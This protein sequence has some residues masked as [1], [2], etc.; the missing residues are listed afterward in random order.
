MGTSL[1][2]EN[3]EKRILLI[4]GH[5]VMLDRDLASIYGVSTGRLNEQV[6]RNRRRFP[7]DFMFQLTMEEAV[8][9]ISQNAISNSWAKKG[10][11][12]PPYAFTEHGAVMLASV[13]NSDIAVS[14]SIQIV[15]AFNTLRRMSLAHQDLALALDKLARKVAGHDEQFKI[16]FRTLR[17]LIAPP[18]RPRKQIG[19]VP[20]K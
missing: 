7:D 17:R 16:V 20:P 3:L 12:K 6:K 10:L 2:P 8:N 11:R 4:R 15:R 19:F 13:L 1:E 5:R 14:A 18:A 9:W